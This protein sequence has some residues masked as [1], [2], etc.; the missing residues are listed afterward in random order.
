M[1]ASA[2]A[3]RAIVNAKLSSYP[4]HGAGDAAVKHTLTGEE[5][6]AILDA[7][8]DQ[9]IALDIER[10]RSARLASAARDVIARWDSPQWKWD[11]HTGV[12][13]AEL[14]VAVESHLQ[15]AAPPGDRLADEGGLRDALKSSR[16]APSSARTR[17]P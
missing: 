17:T 13:I 9:A 16:L 1:T 7:L 15:N 3:A 4:D 2:V 11:E 8:A 10:N 6:E 5:L 14:R 12:F